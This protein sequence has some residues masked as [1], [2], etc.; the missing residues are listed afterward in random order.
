MTKR[1]AQWLLA[2]CALIALPLVQAPARAQAPCTVAPDPDPATNYKNIMACLASGGEAN[3]QAGAF[4]LAHH[5]NLPPRSKL[6]GSTGAPSTLAYQGSGENTI[7]LLG[8][9]NVLAHLRIGAGGK[10]GTV[11]NSAIVKISGDGNSVTD[12][13]VFDQ[14]DSPANVAGIYFIGADMKHNTVERANIHDV[15]NGVIFRKGQNDPTQ[16]V[17]ADSKVTHTQCDAVNLAGGGTV[18]HNTIAEVGFAC[19]NNIPAAGIYAI[20]NQEGAEIANNTVSNSCG[21][22]LDIVNSRNFRIVDNSFKGPGFVA[23]GRYPACRGNGGSLVN[24]QGFTFS[25]NTIVAADRPPVPAAAVGEKWAGNF[26][27]RSHL[28]HPLNALRVVY[29]AQYGDVQTEG[30]VF[31]NN[32]IQASCGNRAHCTGL[33]LFVGGNTGKGAPNVFENNR[34]AGSNVPSVRCGS[35]SYKGNDD[36]K[37]H[38]HGNDGC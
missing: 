13:E 20:N 24:V 12:T 1:E 17:L 29:A 4:P 3:L 36:D 22:L 37:S 27:A 38:P 23:G 25:G 30:N 35:N 5:I 32:T 33:G 15:F 34:F 31:E 28:E 21:N 10:L 11:R 16:N 9:G 19:G 18:R 6:V 26:A 7:V 8:Q 14:P 2:A